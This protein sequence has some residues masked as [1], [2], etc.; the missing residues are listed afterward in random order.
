MASSAKTA[1]STRGPKKS[2]KIQIFLEKVRNFSVL[3]KGNCQQHGF[4]HIGAHLVAKGVLGHMGQIQPISTCIQ[5]KSAKF[6][7]IRVFFV[8]SKL[9]Y[10]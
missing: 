2:R 9:H 7:K 5:G 3:D 8:E 6:F 1:E 4:L 10:V